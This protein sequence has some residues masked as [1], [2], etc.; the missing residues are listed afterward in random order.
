VLKVCKIQI[1]LFTTP[2]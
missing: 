2:L 1:C